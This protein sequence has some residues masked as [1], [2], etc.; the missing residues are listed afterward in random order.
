LGHYWAT[1]SAG[2]PDAQA[3]VAAFYR[4]S[5]ARREC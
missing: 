2:L 5:R 1:R 3:V 4:S